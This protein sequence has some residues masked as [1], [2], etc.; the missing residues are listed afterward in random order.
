MDRLNA[1][2]CVDALAQMWARAPVSSFVLFFCLC[3]GA[4]FALAS[5][6]PPSSP[7]ADTAVLA[8]SAPAK[9]ASEALQVPN[10]KAPDGA[11]W[12]ERIKTLEDR[13]RAAYL[14][15]LDGQ[16]KSMD[17]WFSFLAVFTTL[18]GIGGALIPYLLN[19]KDKEVL[20]LEIAAAK[21]AR[22][23]IES[24]QAKADE[25]Q[26]QQHKQDAQNAAQQARDTTKEA[27]QFLRNAQ[28]SP[29][30]TEAE[31]NQQTQAAQQVL[32]SLTAEPID[33]FRAQA[34]EA[35]AKQDAELA[36]I[37]WRRVLDLAPTDANAA[38]NYAYWL[39]QKTKKLPQASLTDWQAVSAAYAVAQQHDNLAAPNFWIPNNWGV[40]LFDEAQALAGRGDLPA[41][42]AKWAQAGEKYA[43]ALDIK[44]DMHDAAN[45]WGNALAAEAGALAGSGD[46]PAAQAKWAQA[47]E[48]FAQALGIKPGM[49]EAAN[50]WGIGL[51]H[52]YQALRKTDKPEDARTAEQRLAQ[53]QALLEKHAAMSEAGK[54]LVAYNLAC[55]YSLQ[56]RLSEALAQLEIDR[57]AAINFP[58]PEHLKTDDDLASLRATPEYKAWFQQHFPNN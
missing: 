27:A 11:D 45:N 47:G 18:V 8:A 32:A 29:N 33:K 19:R 49:H 57:V 5:E 44:P 22:E 53:A 52:E 30:R 38:F 14:A 2:T 42:Q 9:S 51:L 54:Q 40:A 15:V 6:R 41:A 1:R 23:E 55:C 39:Q 26:T 43:Q 3:A 17:W 10:S 46:L 58:D 13:E 7:H 31:V 48:K 21:K 36:T 16:R 35:G 50:N 56:G 20:A 25:L 12:G 37:L 24:S 4:A 34:V 28:A